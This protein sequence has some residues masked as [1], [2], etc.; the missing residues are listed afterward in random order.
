VTESASWL[1]VAYGT[2]ALALLFVERARTARS[3][4]DVVSLFIIISA[5]Q[6]VLPGVIIYGALPF[7]SPAAPTG[8]RFFDRVLT[9]ADPAAALA[10][11]LLTLWFYASFYFTVSFAKYASRTR[12]ASPRELHVRHRWLLTI[13]LVGGAIT[14]AAFWSLGDSML[15]R[16]ATLILFR[17]QFQEIERSAFTANALFLTQAWSWLSVVLVFAAL[18]RRLFRSIL[19]IAVCLAVAFAVLSVSRRAVFI[20]L[21]MS[22]L[23][24]VATSGR[25]HAR[26]LAVGAVP[27]GFWLAFGKSILG[28]F[29][30]GGTV[31]G[32]VD[33]YSS[34]SSGT[35]RA[36]AEAGITILE[37]VA[38]LSW[39]DLRPRFGVDHLMAALKL[40]PEGA[41]GLNF[42]YPE[43][44]VRLSTAA[45]LDPM[46]LDVPPGLLGQMWLDFGA[47]GPLAWG[48][49]MGLQVAFLQL[50]WCTLRRSWTAA[51]V[52]VVLLFIVALPVNT[53]SY[54]FTFSIDIVIVVVALALVARH[55]K[56]QSNQ[57]LGNDGPV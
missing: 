21:L 28:A 37:S 48:I 24:L 3:G 17:D 56:M 5:L 52:L 10:V 7:V 12:L 33:S 50:L 27:M 39:L 15:L 2:L 1:A 47:L 54:D 13:L 25:W 6:I 26:W 42:N 31:A 18:E 41:L 19:P 40:L 44:I 11:L 35:L 55:A 43:R 34:W 51:S 49:V 4:P 22:Y 30:Y 20:P 38:T 23:I 53:G 36:G 8:N 45:F 46:A 9:E 32:V 29:A 16:Y 14:L 57:V